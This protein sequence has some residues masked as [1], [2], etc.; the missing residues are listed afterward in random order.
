MALSSMNWWTNSY[1]S[2]SKEKLKDFYD[3]QMIYNDKH[4][5]F[6]VFGDGIKLKRVN[7]NAILEGFKGF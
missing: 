2:F 5:E 1:S 4:H 6:I 7:L 3:R